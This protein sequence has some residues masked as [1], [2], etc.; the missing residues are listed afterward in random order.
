ML[1]WLDFAAPVSP[2]PIQVLAGSVGAQVLSLRD[3]ESD[4]PVLGQVAN[5]L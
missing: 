5:P 2:T 4:Q 3:D 1:F